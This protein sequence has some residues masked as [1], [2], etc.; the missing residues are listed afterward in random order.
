MLGS[1]NKSINGK[2]A[3]SMFVLAG[4]NVRT[5]LLM[6]RGMRLWRKIAELLKGFASPSN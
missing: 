4:G 5:I 2:D 6:V 3:S 1:L